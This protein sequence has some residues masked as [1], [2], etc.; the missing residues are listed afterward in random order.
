MTGKSLK[1]KPVSDK[2][3]NAETPFAALHSDV[4]PADLFYVRNHFDVPSLDINQFSLIINGAAAKQNQLSIEQLKKFPERDL[5]VVME[6]AGNGRASMNPTIKGTPWNLGAIS[7]A[8]F[9]GTSLRNILESVDYTKNA[10]EVRFTGMDQGMVRTG[11]MAQFARSLPLEV[12]LHEDTMLAWQMNGDPLPLQHGFPLRLVVPSWYG[13]A[14]VKWLEEIAVLTEP[15]E[16]FFQTKE[17]VYIDE[18]GT[19]NET[20][21]SNMRVRS[22]I[23]EPAD[24]SAIKKDTIQ[25]SGVAWT[26]KGSITK[27]EFSF[28]QGTQWIEVN[29]D[30]PTSPYGTYRWKYLWRPETPGQY[31]IA[32]RAYD[33]EGNIQPLNS[34]WNKGG[35]GNNVIHQLKIS[36]I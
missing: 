29:I 28:D 10:I 23:L 26:G 6:C 11:G 22:L 18:D 34:R 8:N 25:V 7:Q 19:A 21:V 16:G 1:L 35:Y 20:P 13:M 5:H 14:S 31:T 30:P 9:T 27:V 3:F 24:G 17:Y 4:T 2:P 36:I 33:S 12:A 15:F 32:V